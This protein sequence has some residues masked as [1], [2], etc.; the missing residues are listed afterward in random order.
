MA[1]PELKKP[2]GLDA[3]TWDNLGFVQKD[4]IAAAYAL[5]GKTFSPSDVSPADRKLS[6][7]RVSAVIRSLML[8]GLIKKESRGQYA[9]V[10]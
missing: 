8:L 1:A 5:K 3:T 6:R 10:K 9:L 7:S 2:R 4:I